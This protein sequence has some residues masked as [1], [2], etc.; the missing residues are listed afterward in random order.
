MNR[1]VKAFRIAGE[2]LREIFE[3]SAYARYLAR[4]GASVGRSSYAAFLRE[5]EVLKARRPKCC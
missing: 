4:H 5:Q 3:E 2:I 1:L